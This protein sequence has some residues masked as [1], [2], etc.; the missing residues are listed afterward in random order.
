MLKVPIGTMRDWEQERR[1]PRDLSL[2]GCGSVC[3]S[4]RLVEMRVQKVSNNRLLPSSFVE[5]EVSSHNSRI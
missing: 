2:N 4:L 1:S 3:A 5:Q